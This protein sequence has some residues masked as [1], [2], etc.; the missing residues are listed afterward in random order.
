M[1]QIKILGLDISKRSATAWI[2]SEIPEDPKRYAR[3]QKKIKLEADPEGREQLLSLDFDCAV[4]EPTG[5]YS[6]IWRQWL[7]SAGKEVRL[8]GHNELANYRNAWKLQK[9]DKLD[10]L[11]LA[12]Y[13]VERWSRKSSWLVE[14]DYTLSDLVSLLEHLNTQKNGYQNNLRQRLVWQLPEWHE[15]KIFR[16]WG[17]NSPGILKAIAGIEVSAKWQKEIDKTCGCGLRA[18]AQGLGRILLQIEAE[19]RTI[20]QAIDKELGAEKYKPYLIA[21]DR[22]EFSQ[23]LTPIM[24]AAI[25]P[26]E[27]FLDNGKRRIARS[28]SVVNDKPVKRDESLRAFKLACGM[29]QVFIQSGDYEGWTAG[30][31]ASTRKALWQSIAM[32]YIAE[33]GRINK[34]LLPAEDSKFLPMKN[35]FDNQGAMKVARKWVERYYSE[36][37]K[38]EW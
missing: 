5:V 31:S 35:R 10:S 34:G 38:M 7:K 28:R 26:F 1:N 3:T 29:G 16:P 25:F 6:R 19:E 21:A 12:M 18:D 33:K 20:E 14:R 9:M 27:Q 13:G 11:A 15:R 32:S 36:L 2:L 17:G 22:C 8:V 24:I 23:G 30:G 37:I 4:C